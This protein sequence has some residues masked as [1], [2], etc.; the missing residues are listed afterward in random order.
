MKLFTLREETGKPK[1][2]ETAKMQA[3]FRG[4]HGTLLRCK[5][6]QEIRYFECFPGQMLIIERTDLPE[7]LPID[8]VLRTEKAK[9]SRGSPVNVDVQRG[10]ELPFDFSAYSQGSA[11]IAGTTSNKLIIEQ[12][13]S[14]LSA[15]TG[16]G[17]SVCVPDSYASSKTAKIVNRIINGNYLQGERDFLFK[18]AKGQTTAEENRAYWDKVEHFLVQLIPFVGCTDDLQ[19]GDRM[20]FINGAFGCFADLI[21]GLSALAGGA[22]RISKSLSSVVPISIKAFEAVKITG[23]T[24]VSLIN[25]LDGMPDLIVGGGRAIGSFRKVLAS[26]VFSLT[27]AGASHLQTC[28]ERLRGFFGGMAS[29]T[30]SRLPRSLTNSLGR[31]NGTSATATQINNKW[32]VLDTNG[33]PIGRA[34]DNSMVQPL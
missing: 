20:R 30:A 32:Y 13:G 29:G 2:D 1:E 14:T 27:E 22:A 23:T 28:V 25:P 31:V 16:S 24:I 34:L 26:G 11:P 5:Y 7:Y 18:K 19:S 6:Q 12:L 9:V 8:G 15:T 3:A 4:R 10:T 33:N 17:Q 21:A